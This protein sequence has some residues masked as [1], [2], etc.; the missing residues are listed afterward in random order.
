MM[1][2]DS[3]GTFQSLRDA[4]ASTWRP[5]WLPR[6]PRTGLGPGPRPSGAVADPD[7]VHARALWATGSFRTPVSTGLA[8]TAA[9]TVS[10][11][12][13]KAR[14]GIAAGPLAFTEPWL[15]RPVLERTVLKR[16]R[17]TR[18]TLRPGTPTTGR[19][20]AGDLGVRRTIEA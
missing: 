8:R 20:V 4:S 18:C 13:G 7:D 2:V 5:S 19:P 11:Q 9:T 15:A 1:P 16:R 14:R 10:S 6:R 12:T 17:T 3:P